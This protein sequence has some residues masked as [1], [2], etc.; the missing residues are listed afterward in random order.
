MAEILD[1]LFDT[2]Q[3]RRGA[4]PQKSYVAQLHQKGLNQILKKVGEECAEVLLSAKDAAATGNTH[5][6]VHETAD[7]WFH[8]LV[9]LSHL[10]TSHRE[11]LAELE[12]RFDLSGLAEKAGRPS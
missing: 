12:R 9:M 6:V 1:S 2:L 3:S 11:V 10:G 8:T 7:L 4:D 5:D